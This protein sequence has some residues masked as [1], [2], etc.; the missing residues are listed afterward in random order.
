MYDILILSIT[1]LDLMLLTSEHIEL[2]MIEA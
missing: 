1:L 2:L